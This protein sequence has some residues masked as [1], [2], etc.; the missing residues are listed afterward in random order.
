MQHPDRE[1]LSFRR[2][3]PPARAPPGLF[4]H[5][6]VTHIWCCDVTL[7]FVQ[8][9]RRRAASPKGLASKSAITA[10]ARSS[11]SLAVSP[12]AKGAAPRPTRSEARRQTWRR[13]PRVYGGAGAVVCGGAGRDRGGRRGRRDRDAQSQE[14]PQEASWRHGRLGARAQARQVRHGIGGARRPG[15]AD[16]AATRARRQPRGERIQA[17]A[18]CRGRLIGGG[19]RRG[20][21]SV[22]ARSGGGS[23]RSSGDG[24]GDLRAAAACSA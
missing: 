2:K 12:A 24:G 9:D 17:H 21:S 10:S 5:A 6:Y 20:G 11:G 4:A 16:R 19:A 23:G 14:A 15:A 13:Q 1:L 7:T 3:S 22:C 8:R 18:Q